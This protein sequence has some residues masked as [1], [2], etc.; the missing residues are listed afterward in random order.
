M[1][2]IT[3]ENHNHPCRPFSSHR[4]RA[5]GLASFRLRSALRPHRR[6][7][8][9]G[10]QSREHPTPRWPCGGSQR[11]ERLW[12]LWAACCSA[13]GGGE[14][15]DRVTDLPTLTMGSM[16]FQN[17]FISPKETLHPLAVTAHVPPNPSPWQLLICFL[18]LR[19]SLFW[20]F[21]INRI[22]QYAMICVWLLF[23]SMFQG[24]VRVV[25]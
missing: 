22:V 6:Q 8:T 15:T 1:K 23:L 7:L 3:L 13:D 4:V 11:D 21:R 20:T 17:I 10:S 14:A 2:E 24:V 5:A 19:I 12:E 16:W 9:H 25:A 18:L